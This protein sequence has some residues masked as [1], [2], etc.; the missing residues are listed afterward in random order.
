MAWIESHQTIAQHPKTRRSAR[1]LGVTLPAMIGHLHLLWHW[2]LDYAQD[3]DISAYDAVDIA[4]AAMWEGDAEAFVDALV[5]CGP[6][7]AAGFLA[8]D[9][10]RLVIHDW[11]D[12]AGKLVARRQADAERKRQSRNAPISSMEEDERD[13]SAGHPADGAETAYVTVPNPTVTQPTEPD[14]GDPPNPPAVVN[15]PYMAFA[16]ICEA[17][18]TEPHVLSNDELRKQL[19]ATKRMLERGETA[20]T[21]GNCTGWMVSQGWRDG[22]IDAFAVEKTLPGWKL[23]GCPAIATARASPKRGGARNGEKNGNDWAREIAEEEARERARSEE[24]HH[25]SR[26]TLAELPA[27][28]D[29]DGWLHPSAPRRASR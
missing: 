21:I 20:E 16:A 13:M 18:G 3:G 4:E 8:Y 25:S 22:G 14:G 15:E 12:Y 1:T 23:K 27:G 5:N 29:D 28:R 2:A 26:G 24:T 7:D 17:Q 9:D 11:W 6:G 10:G 19:R